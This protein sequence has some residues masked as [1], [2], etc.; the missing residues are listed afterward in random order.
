MIYNTINEKCYVGQSINIKNRWISHKKVAKY[1]RVDR[2]FYPL[3][4]GMR[5]Y[6]INNFEFIVLELVNRKEDLLE[7]EQFWYEE[8]EPEYNIIEPRQVSNCNKPVYQIERHT[9]KVLKLYDSP[10]EFARERNV[11][12]TSIS[13]VARGIGEY[14]YDYHWCY[15]E[16]YNKNWMPI[17]SKLKVRVAKLNKH[18]L[19]EIKRYDSLLMASNENNITS[20][21]N[22][23]VAIRKSGTCGGY[24]WKLI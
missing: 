3:Y 11:D 8:L 23:R 4:R 2:N 6:G 7:K 21:N 17:Q 16:R 20:P 15:K 9:L 13:K 10:S 5:K 12:P 24:R 1:G 19:E 22:I 14:A 18:T